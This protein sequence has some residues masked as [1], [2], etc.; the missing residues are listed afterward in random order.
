MYFGMFANE[1]KMFSIIQM[2]VFCVI[3]GVQFRQGEPFRVVNFEPPSKNPDF[4]RVFVVLGQIFADSYY[5][6]KPGGIVNIG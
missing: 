6:Q 2:T 4:I 3:A 1:T 5:M